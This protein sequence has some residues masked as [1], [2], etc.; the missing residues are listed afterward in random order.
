MTDT[1][2]TLGRVEARVADLTEQIHSLRSDVAALTHTVET[3]L[4]SHRVRIAALESFRRW[5]IGLLTG[6]M[7]SGVATMISRYV[8]ILP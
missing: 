7:L 2:R 8:Q 1:D 5:A 3:D 4:T 6:V